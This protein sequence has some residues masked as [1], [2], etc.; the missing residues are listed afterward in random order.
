MNRTKKVTHPNKTDILFIKFRKLKS[1]V[2]K[3]MNDKNDNKYQIKFCFALSSIKFNL[4][5]Q[6]CFKFNKISNSKLYIN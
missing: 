1:S 2:Y 6:N 4:T 5:D 3:A